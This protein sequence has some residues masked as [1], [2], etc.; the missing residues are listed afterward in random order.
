VAKKKQVDGG[1][2]KTQEGN[3]TCTFDGCTIEIST[4][5]MN[6]KDGTLSLRWYRQ[7]PDTFEVFGARWGD[8]D[9]W[10]KVSIAG[11]GFFMAAVA[12]EKETTVAS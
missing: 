7:H 11:L 6:F 3:R 8:G 1:W 4:D 12:K 9:F 5:W 2:S 10:T